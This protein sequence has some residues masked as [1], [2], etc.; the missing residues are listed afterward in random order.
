MIV[1]PTQSGCRSCGGPLQIIDSCNASA[2]VACVECGDTY[3]ME[4]DPDAFESVFP[5]EPIA[6][7]VMEEANGSERRSA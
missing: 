3:D 6:Q 7:C 1:D 2:T 4:A 5:V